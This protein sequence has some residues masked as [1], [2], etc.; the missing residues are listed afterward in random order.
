AH[1]RST[2]RDGARSNVRAVGRW[3]RCDGMA[4]PRAYSGAGVLVHVVAIRAIQQRLR[5]R[6]G[7]DAEVARPLAEFRADEPLVERLQLLFVGEV[8][9]QRAF[10][11]D[12]PLQA[13]LH[14]DS[15]HKFVFKDLCLRTLRARRAA[16]AVRRELEGDLIELPRPL[17]GLTDAQLLGD[18][19]VLQP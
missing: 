10:A 15:A 11:F 16:T 13:R 17:L 4:V 8:E 14:L 9:R 7:E 18:D 19:D 2:R 1:A 6:T 5:S 12:R 3:R